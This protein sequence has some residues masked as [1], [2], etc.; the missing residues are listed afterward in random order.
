MDIEELTLL[1]NCIRIGT[2]SISYGAD[3]EKDKVAGNLPKGYYQVS[4]NAWKARKMLEDL[5]KL[6]KEAQ[7]EVDDAKDLI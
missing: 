6:D 4:R 5:S 3:V 1:K 2:Q 7:E